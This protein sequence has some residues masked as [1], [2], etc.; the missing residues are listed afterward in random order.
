[1]NPLVILLVFVCVPLMVGLVCLARMPLPEEY[2]A[3]PAEKIEDL[4]PLHT[5]HFP[6]LKQALASA[7]KQYIG[8]RLSKENRRLWNEERGKIL[9]SFLDGL[10]GDFGRLIRFGR[11]VDSLTADSARPDEMERMWLALRFRLHYRILSLAISGTG[12]AT[13][14]QLRLLTESVGGLSALAETAMMRVQIKTEEEGVPSEFN[15]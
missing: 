6:Q 1:M 11:V 3:D 2:P 4:F 15:A 10:V 9:E 5:Q 8:Q 12:G 13:I 14:W 7:D